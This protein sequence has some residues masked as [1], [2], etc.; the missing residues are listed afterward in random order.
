[1]QSHLRTS[2]FHQFVRRNKKTRGKPATNNLIKFYGH[3]VTV[4][5]KGSLGVQFVFVLETK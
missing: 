4:A 5:K 2:D 1:M 3:I